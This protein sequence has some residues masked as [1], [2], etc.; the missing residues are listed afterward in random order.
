L[1]QIDD[2]AGLS[3]APRVEGRKSWIAAGGILGAIAAS[4]CCILPLVLFSLGI[5]GVWIGNLTALAPYQPIFVV[6]TLGFLGYGYWL[7]YRKSKEDCADGTAC[8]RPLPNRIV[9][10]SLWLATALVAAALAFPY[11]APVLLDT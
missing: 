10:L 3:A 2:H 9:K 4:S 6:I 1:A 11:I 5:G 7:V 8:A